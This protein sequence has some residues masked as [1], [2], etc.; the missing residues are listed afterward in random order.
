MVQDSVTALPAS[1][2]K[3]FQT[4]TLVNCNT[5]IVSRCV[6]GDQT[7]GAVPRNVPVFNCVSENTVLEEIEEEK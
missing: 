6:K 3:C 1:S 2:L 7:S 4:H 5:K